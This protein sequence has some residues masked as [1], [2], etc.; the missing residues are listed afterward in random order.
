M[1]AALLTNMARGTSTSSNRASQQRRN[2]RVVVPVI[3]LAFGGR[4]YQSVDW[5]LG[6]FLIEPYVGEMRVDREFMVDAIG[7][8]DGDLIKMP[9]RARVVRNSRGRLAASFVDLSD[10]AFDV[11]EALMMRR[12]K[13]LEAKARKSA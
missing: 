5:S 4:Y 9:I 3:R 7:P 12:R 1:T 8:G 2:N 10:T 6:G 11:L 13:Y